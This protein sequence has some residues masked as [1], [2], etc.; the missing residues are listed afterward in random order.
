MWSALS[1]SS[2]ARINRAAL[3]CGFAC[4]ALGLVAVAGTPARAQVV[5]DNGI[6][7]GSPNTFNISNATVADDFLVSNSLSFNAIRLYLMDGLPG[8]LGN[9]SG[10]LSW[11]I[12]ADNGVA[13]P[14]GRPST[15]VVASGFT[16]NATITNT[17][18]IQG[19]VPDFEIAQVD[20]AIP[21]VNLGAGR[22]W[23][24]IKEGTPSSTYDGSDI[25]W[26]AT[27]AAVQG[28]PLRLD[29]TENNPSVWNGTT[30]NL[31]LA[32]QLRD[33]TLAAAPEPGSLALAGFSLLACIAATRKRQAG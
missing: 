11:F 9:Y 27:S 19:G 15:T 25:F 28:N 7:I 26:A 4:L 1:Q 21:T 16:T 33:T 29:N 20:F 18:L 23:L 8:L 5:Y 17:G 31:D 13:V 14:G 12:H 32:F 6:V 2:G 3:T 30:Q 24:R 22:Y 10:T